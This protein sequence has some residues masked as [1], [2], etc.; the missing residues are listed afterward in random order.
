MFRAQWRPS[1]RTNAYRC[2]AYGPS[3]QTRPGPA[4][5]LGQPVPL[6]GMAPAPELCL[7]YI[8]SLLLT[9][10]C[11]YDNS[12][13]QTPRGAV[14]RGFDGRGQTT[15]ALS[16]KLFQALGVGRACVFS[17]HRLSF[18]PQKRLVSIFL[19]CPVSPPPLH[20]FLRPPTCCS[21][22]TKC[23]WPWR[24]HLKVIP[25][26]N[27]SWLRGRRLLY[28]RLPPGAPET[29]VLS[30]NNRAPCHQAAN[31]FQFGFNF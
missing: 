23:L 11:F 3:E 15:V 5:Q 28:I 14:P 6:P 25:S 2:L 16:R 17:R 31:G 29:A 22:K 10:P 12:N 13:I 7:S 20:L 4:L 19:T 18:H 30:C 1:H 24:K 27:Y 8:P 26:L 21:K 9:L